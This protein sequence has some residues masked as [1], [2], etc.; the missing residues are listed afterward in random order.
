MKIAICDDK[1]QDVDALRDMLTRLAESSVIDCFETGEAFLAAAGE[2]AYD[3]VFMDIYLPG[4]NGVEVIRRMRG[5]LPDAA[6]AFTTVSDSHA[7]DAFSVY[8][9]HYLVKPYTEADVVETLRRA[10][11]QDFSTA[12]KSTLTVRIGNDMYEL[13]QRDI[14]R[15]EASDHKTNIFTK[16]G[17]VYSIW[18]LFGKVEAQ[19]DKSFL[20]INRGVSL[21]MNHIAK[22]RAYDCET[23][24][25]KL[26]LLNRRRRQQLKEAYFAF[27]MDALQA[28]NAR[29]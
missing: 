16:N 21:N 13:D 4:E 3:L 6:V 27:Q 9:I 28:E 17:S 10:T 24:D 23:S 5:I 18:M 15:V 2:R 26:F 29:K 8:A 19:L 22:W 14:I 7:V 12:P 25:G 1:R 11:K 20:T